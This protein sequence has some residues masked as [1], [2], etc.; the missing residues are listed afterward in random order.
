VTPQNG[1]PGNAY[2]IRAMPLWNYCRPKLPHRHNPHP[3][4]LVV[5]LMAG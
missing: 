3:E 5:Q 1:L 2:W 4:A